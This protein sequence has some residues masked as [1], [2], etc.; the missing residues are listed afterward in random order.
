MAKNPTET[1]HAVNLGNLASAV[2][3]ISSLGPAFAPS[4]D[5]IKKDA[6]QD[7]VAEC[8]RAHDAVLGAHETYDGAV[9]ERRSKYKVLKRLGTRVL[10]A[11]I[12][13]G[14]DAGAVE[15]LR[16]IN[17]RLQGDTAKSIAD[18]GADTEGKKAYSNSQQGFVNLAAHFNEMLLRCSRL[19]A[20][21]PADDDI[22]VPAL[23]AFVQ[24]LADAN[25][26]VDTAAQAFRAARTA[27]DRMFYDEDRGMVARSQLLR[28]YFKSRKEGGDPLKGIRFRSVG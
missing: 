19:A 22:K 5:S 18:P 15:D 2:S 10:N 12:A 1:G 8:K 28:S 26:R 9:N 14:A 16:G 24:A 17:R 25:T 21:A 7:Y 20:Y 3:I 11:Y 13:A 4:H 27:R 23:Q 6:L